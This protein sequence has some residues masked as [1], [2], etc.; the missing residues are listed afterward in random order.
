MEGKS[1]GLEAKCR[2]PE[3]IASTQNQK[4]TSK[5]ARV[6]LQ[7]QELRGI[8]RSSFQNLHK[9]STGG[10]CTDRL[11]RQAFLHNGNLG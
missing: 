11:S 8:D 10:C 7:G 2:V 5:A 4:G 3:L 9:Q 6:L 1:F